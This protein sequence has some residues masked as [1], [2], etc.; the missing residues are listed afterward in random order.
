M[1]GKPKKETKPVTPAAAPATTTGIPDMESPDFEKYIESDAFTKLIE[2][3]DQLSA[4]L[5]DK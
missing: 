2:S 4:L 5:A 1:K 3:E